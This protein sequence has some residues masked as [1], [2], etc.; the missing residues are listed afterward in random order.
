[1]TRRTH[2]RLTLLAIL[3]LVCQQVAF[4]AY[5]C[6]LTVMPTTNAAMSAGCAAMAT[7]TP[8]TRV[9][10]TSCV[11]HCAQPAGTAQSTD[12]TPIHTPV[13]A[14]ILPSAPPLALLI[15]PS[16]RVPHYFDSGPPTHGL[17]AALHY[18][19]LLI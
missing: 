9:A 2:L 1:M 8:D 14:A 16:R 15:I 10:T 19:V 3:A 11:L 6:P 12:I 7:R 18:R 5:V 4:A 13:I 17:A